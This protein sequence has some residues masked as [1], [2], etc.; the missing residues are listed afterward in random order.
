MPLPQ[1]TYDRYGQLGGRVSEEKFN[2]SLR[3]AESYVR[4]IIGFNDPEDAPEAYER[5]VC[6]AV[7]VDVYYGSTGGIG[8]G[9]SSISIGS[10]SASMGA[11]DASSNYDSDMQSAIRRELIGSG[12]LYRGIG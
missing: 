3:A 1:L 7:D 10:F 4:E 11:S 9:V 6:A 12:L 2:A 8:E 5:A